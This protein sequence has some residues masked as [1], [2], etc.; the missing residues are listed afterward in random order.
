M[1]RI[2]CIGE[3]L[4]DFIC[5]DVD[6]GLVKGSNFIKKAGGAPANVSAAIAKLGGNA[7]FAGKVGADAFGVFLNN[8]LEEVGVDT[9]MLM[10]DEN[11][12]TT[13]AFVSLAS[14][15]ERDFIFNRGADEKLTFEDIDLDK[16]NDSKI[17][18]FG[19][20]TGFLG[21]DLTETYF[22]LM[23]LAKENNIFISFDPNYR[24]DLWKGNIQTFLDYSIKALKLADFA[25][26]SDEEIQLI[27][28]KEDL[29]EGI[30]VLHEYGV[31]VICV[32]LGKEGTLISVKGEKA[33]VES[34]KITSVDSTGAGD[35]FVGGT[36]YKLAEFDNPKETIE[37]LDNLKKVIGFANKVGAI[38]CTKY[39]AISSLPTLKEAENFGKE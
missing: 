30:D 2:V 37:N 32:T 17:I 33:I 24:V 21:G 12:N 20:A 14:D 22:K 4:I 28:G 11:S 16:F 9:S 25:K 19:S 10:Q 26:V 1:N 18:H 35:A 6:S 39:G 34:V 36:L 7:T 3:L 5:S 27:S 31:K 38:V 13:L 29:K 15:G 8:T 23:E